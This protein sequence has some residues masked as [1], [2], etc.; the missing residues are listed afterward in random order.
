MV[1]PRWSSTG[2]EGSC[3]GGV[4]RCPPPPPHFATA[5][6]AGASSED[7]G[8]ALPAV[9]VGQQRTRA[10]FSLRKDSFADI[11]DSPALQVLSVHSISFLTLKQILPVH[12][13]AAVSARRKRQRQ[14]A[15]GTESQQE[16]GSASTGA[17]PP[18]RAGLRDLYLVVGRRSMR[19]GEHPSAPAPRASLSSQPLEVGL[20]GGLLPNIEVLWMDASCVRQFRLVEPLNCLRELHLLL[21]LTFV[22]SSLVGLEKLRSLQVLHLE[23]ILLND[24]AFLGESRSLRELLLHSCRVPFLQDKK[25]PLF[26]VERAPSLELLSLAYTLDI[27]DVTN[28]AA[29]QT[30]RK[31]VLSRCNGISSATVAGLQGLPKLE[32]LS[33]EYTRISDVTAF[34]K[35]KSLTT[36]RLDGCKRILRSAILG[37]EMNKTLRELSLSGTN[38]VTVANLGAGSSQIACLDLSDCTHLDVAGLQGIQGLR[39]LEVLNLSR[40]PLTDLHFLADCPALVSLYVEG[41]DTLDAD[42]V[43]GLQSILSLRRLV[44]DGCTTITKVG[45][46][47]QRCAQLQTLS[48]SHCPQLTNES[49]MGVQWIHSLEYLDMTGCTGLNSV[50]FLSRGCH[51]LRVLK[52]GGCLLL[53][54][55]S[56]CGLE[57]LPELA[58]LEL[59]S[60]PH[61][62]D[63]GFLA[64]SP[65]LRRLSLCDCGNLTY[66]GIAKLLRTSI[67]VLL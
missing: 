49:V 22:S 32:V 12:R 53:S 55:D 10:R 48:L 44:L 17:A 21:D 45:C 26:G 5:A 2:D 24:L 64:A 39:C 40:T 51:R 63:A 57:E 58:D 52:L 31:V 14:R 16:P 13:L 41:C 11:L 33:M 15:Q 19:S 46:F 29:C 1:L 36:L 6:A 56:L 61:L 38:V 66:G 9:S 25:T 27:K 7:P 30:L 62:T 4:Q 37:I 65:V 47:L 54:Q 18:R 34:A 28:F 23:H 20:D 35:C 3:V 60:L 50:C 59:D 43:D 67:S 8:V 42:A